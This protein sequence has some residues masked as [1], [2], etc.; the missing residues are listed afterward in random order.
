[1][2]CPLSLRPSTYERVHLKTYENV[3]AAHADIA[4]YLAW[5]NTY[6]VHPSLD[7]LTPDAACFSELSQ[8]KADRIR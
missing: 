4:D 7:R 2:R 3:S 1:M 8:L 5:Y 6:R